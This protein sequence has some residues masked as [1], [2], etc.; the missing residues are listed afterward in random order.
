MTACAIASVPLVALQYMG[1]AVGCTAMLVFVAFD[2]WQIAR[3][4][5]REQR[6]G[7]AD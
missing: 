7:N 3:G 1:M 2:F 5:P 6:Y 4:V